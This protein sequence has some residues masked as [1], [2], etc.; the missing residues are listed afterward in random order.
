[1]PRWWALLFAIPF[2]LTFDHGFMNAV[3]PIP[4][5]VGDGFCGNAARNFPE[6]IAAN[7]RADE[8]RALLL[9][10]AV[11][12]LATALTTL[13]LPRTVIT[14]DR[15]ARVVRVQTK[16]GQWGLAFGDRPVLV[17]RDGAYF[18]HG[19]AL[20]PIPIASR[21]APRAAI[22]RLRAALASLA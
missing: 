6:F 11:V 18:L 14:F 15:A 12:S 16:K 17:Q 4:A 7:G 2:L 1:M 22:D 8:L 21:W 20:A 10:L 13:R 9:L 3:V 5:L 19:S